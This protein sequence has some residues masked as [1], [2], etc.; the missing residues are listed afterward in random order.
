MKYLKILGI[1]IFPVALLLFWWN[2]SIVISNFN[3]SEAAV[4]NEFIGFRIL[5]VSDLHNEEF[6]TDNKK[7]IYKIKN[8]NPDIIVITGDTV[9]SRRTD[10]D[11]SL[12]FIKQVIQIAPTYYVI[13]NHE[14]RVYD[15]YLVFEKKM[16]DLGVHVLRNQSELITKNNQSLQIIGMDDPDIYNSTIDTNDYMYE[17]LNQ[18]NDPEKY[19]I[20][21][22]HRPELFDLYSDANIDL[23]FSGHVHGGQVRIPFVGGLVGPHQ[24][25]LP[26][27]DAGLYTDENT[28][29]I[30]SRGLGN[31][32]FPFR[33]NNRPEITVTTLGE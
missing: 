15:E 31:S 7:L 21:L 23:V 4:P 13:G 30:L 17:I 5:Q 11:I 3:I 26:K 6:G 19:T 16:I 8:N 10:F 1:F 24:G 22:S 20:L 14:T 27:Y 2:K 25:L 32:L 33:I 29:M 9:D 28:N 12:D 18:L